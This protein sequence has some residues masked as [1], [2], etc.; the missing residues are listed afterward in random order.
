M[1]DYQRIYEE[2]GDAYDA[3]VSR[4]DHRQN[5]IAALREIAPL[6]GADVVETGAGTG[7]VS[8]LLAPFVHAVRAFD[9]AAPMLS[10]AEKRRRERSVENVRFAVASH[11][12]LPVESASADL[13]IEGWAFGHAL[14]W[15][16]SGWEEEVDAYVRE[17]A[18]TVRAGGM[19]ILIETMGT[20]VE[21]PFEGGHSLEPFHRHVVE[22][23]GFAHRC[24]STDY[25]FESVDEAAARLAFFFGDRM[26]EKA[27][28]KGWTIVPERTGVYWRRQ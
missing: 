15:N 21:A 17:L 8:F 16:P 20:G 24:V 2:H 5:L 6:A 18:R 22:R 11:A 1:S 9:C 12:S 26:A 28:A 25:A 7:R 19:V 10:V 4:E 13:G 14:G 27:R 23:L 3:L